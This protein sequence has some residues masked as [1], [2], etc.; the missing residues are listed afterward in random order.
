MEVNSRGSLRIV[1][2]LAENTNSIF[3]D[4][5]QGPETVNGCPVLRRRNHAERHICE[6]RVL[7][8]AFLRAPLKRAS[9]ELRL[10]LTKTYMEVGYPDI[11]NAQRRYIQK[12]VSQHCSG[13]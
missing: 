7:A 5:L 10:L 6:L 4:G 11:G 12:W 9:G 2:G 1:S 13:S 8:Y 3:C